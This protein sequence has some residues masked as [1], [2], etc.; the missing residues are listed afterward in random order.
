M[1]LMETATQFKGGHRSTWFDSDAEH[2]GSFVWLCDLFNLDPDRARSM[3]RMKFRALA[4][5]GGKHEPK[6]EVRIALDEVA[7]TDTLET[8]GSHNPVLGDVPRRRTNR[9][10]KRASQGD[11]AC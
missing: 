7:P 4:R 1:G 6:T 5:D 10:P 3:A 9:Q 11:G 2:V 8:V